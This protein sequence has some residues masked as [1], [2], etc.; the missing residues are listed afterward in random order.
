MTHDL[1]TPPDRLIVVNQRLGIVEFELHQVPR[2]PL[3]LLRQQCLAPD[4][5]IRFVE[6]DHK[7]SPA[8]NGESSL[9]MS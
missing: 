2:D 3:L 4:K 5:P 7:P 6:L 1:F 9:V 8:S